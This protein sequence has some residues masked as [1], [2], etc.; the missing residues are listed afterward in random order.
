MQ[1]QIEVLEYYGSDVLKVLY[2]FK[3]NFGE[4]FGM[5]NLIEFGVGL[6]VGV[7]MIKVECVFDG[8]YCIIG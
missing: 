5:M 7:L 1:G 8:I 2:L 6:D 3:L 4:W